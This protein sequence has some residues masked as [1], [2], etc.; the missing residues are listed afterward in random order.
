MSKTAGKT[1]KVK[2]P[3]VQEKAFRKAERGATF[4]GFRPARFKSKKIYDRKRVRRADDET[5]V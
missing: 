3:G 4:V 5:M 1:A 2:N